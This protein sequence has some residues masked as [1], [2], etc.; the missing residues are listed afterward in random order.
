MKP[1]T[2]REKKYMQ[3]HRAD[4]YNQIAV[5]LGK[6]FPEDNGGK[7]AQASVR[8]FLNSD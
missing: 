3:A 5:N 4:F 7:R 1:F 8:R 2:D 6:E